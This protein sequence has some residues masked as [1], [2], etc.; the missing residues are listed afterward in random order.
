MKTT[1]AVDSP[2]LDCRDPILAV[3]SGVNLRGGTGTARRPTQPRT[4]LTWRSRRRLRPDPH[5]RTTLE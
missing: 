4:V 3:T 5:L 2:I 1:G